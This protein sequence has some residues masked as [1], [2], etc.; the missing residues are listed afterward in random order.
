MI[1]NIYLVLIAALLGVSCSK[2]E[3]PLP[4]TGIQAGS[5]YYSAADELM[6]FDFKTKQETLVFSGGSSY[7]ISAAQEK[8]AWYKNDFAEQTT[9]VQVHDLEAPSG[10]ES[11]IISATLESTP[12]FAPGEELLGALA[13]SLDEPD[14]RKDLVLFNYHGAIIG[15]VPHVKDFSFSPNGKDLLISAE[16]L[17]PGNEVEGYALALIKNYRSDDQQSITIREFPDY[18]QLPADISI[19]PDASHVAY[20]HLDHLYTL[21]LIEEA[22]PRQITASKFMEVDACWSPDGKYLGFIANVSGTTDCG[23]IRI[24]L[25]QPAEPVPVPDEAWENAPADPLQPVDNNGKVIHSCG[26][27]RIYWV[28]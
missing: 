19:S 13:E 11:I 18:S 1:M 22:A 20:T 23:E 28:P 7:T 5:L 8:F 9:R 17:N 12:E 24:V 4:A 21:E 14:L 16:A 3:D 27:E 10:Y 26:S 6:R 2:G 15:R 25:S